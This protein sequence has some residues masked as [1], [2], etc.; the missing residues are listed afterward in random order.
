MLCKRETKT[1][2][3][4]VGIEMREPGSDP[5]ITAAQ[6]PIKTSVM[7][8]EAQ[9]RSTARV[10]KSKRRCELAGPDVEFQPAEDTMCDGMQSNNAAC[11]KTELS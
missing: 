4:Y 6:A 5:R 9:K 10:G 3:V 2:R 8:A 11:R 7:R 1:I